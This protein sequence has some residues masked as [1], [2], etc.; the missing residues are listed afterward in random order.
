MWV[1]YTFCLIFILLFNCC[2][3]QSTPSYR[4]YFV[5]ELKDYKIFGRPLAGDFNCDKK[6]DIAVIL[7]KKTEHSKIVLY[8]IYSSG[9]SFIKQKVGDLYDTLELYVRRCNKCVP[10][11]KSQ[12]DYPCAGIYTT[13]NEWNQLFAFD[14]KKNKFI[15]IY[16][17]QIGP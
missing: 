1:H 3:A 17:Y 15:Q 12:S 9:D 13:S 14:S 2:I 7:Q 10:N 5:N 6:K 4:Q 11:F 8:V 16:E